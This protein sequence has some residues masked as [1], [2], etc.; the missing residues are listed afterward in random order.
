MDTDQASAG[1]SVVNLTDHELK[2]ISKYVLVTYFEK[3]IKDL[4]D[5]LDLELKLDPEVA[6]CLPCHKHYNTGRTHVDGP[7]P[8]KKYCWKC[9]EL[10]V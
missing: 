7:A 4:W 2:H 5:R 10:K 3:H 6:S 8:L 9:R 1:K